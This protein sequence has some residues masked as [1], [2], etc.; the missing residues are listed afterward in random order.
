MKAI[1]VFQRKLNKSH[2]IFS[3]RSPDKPVKVEY[4]IT[5]LS[6]E[7]THGFHIHTFGNLYS[8]DCKDCGG[9]WNPDNKKHGSLRSRESH[10]G[11]LGNIVSNKDGVSYNL[12]TTSKITLFG[13]NS[14]IGRS[15]VVHSREDDLGKGGNDESLITGNAGSRLDCAV[16]GYMK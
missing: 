9:H 1:A 3:Q 5:N 13:V 6:P 10:A 7:T 15:V 16:I 12:F 2:V 11:D 4:I 14:I 8:T